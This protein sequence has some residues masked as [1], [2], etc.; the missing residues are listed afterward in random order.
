M[1]G[2]NECLED[3][4]RLFPSQSFLVGLSSATL[5]DAHAFLDAVAGCR[6][7]ALLVA[8]PSY[9]RNRMNPRALSRFFL[10]LAERSPYPVLLYNVPQYSG[11][12]LSP[13]LVG[14]LAGHQAIAG[15]KD[16][17][18]NLLY[19]QRILEATRKQ[20]FQLILGSAQVL[21]PSLSLGIKA[22]IIAVADAFP[23]L[24]VRVMEAFEAGED[25]LEPQLELFRVA[26]ALTSS[27]G[28]PGLKYAMDLAGFEGRACRRPLLPL[29]EAEKEAVRVALKSLRV[30]QGTKAPVAG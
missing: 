15:M 22:A 7:D 14:D 1:R 5:R 6:I 18:G 12:E 21:G 24:P 20:D 26:N 19:V 9:Y 16:S 3:L 29:T 13:E 11:L 27:Y 28:I 8:T 10:E 4:L 2:S 30:G 17:S 25:I 23:H